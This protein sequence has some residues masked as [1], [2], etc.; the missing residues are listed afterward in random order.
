M[1]PNISFNGKNISAKFINNSAFMDGGAVYGYTSTIAFDGNMSIMF[2]ENTGN[3][4]G[5]KLPLHLVT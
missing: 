1:E 4:H 3:R 5:G 2:C